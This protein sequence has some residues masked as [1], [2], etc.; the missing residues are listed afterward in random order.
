MMAEES[1]TGQ[2]PLSATATGRGDDA[3]ARTA[4]PDD[5]AVGAEPTSEGE[6]A[7]AVEEEPEAPPEEEPVEEPEEEL[8]INFPLA[9]SFL[10]GGA[11]FLVVFLASYMSGNH[12]LLAMLWGVVGFVGIASLGYFIEFLLN[13]PAISG[14]K[15]AEVT[16][17][18]PVEEP[19]DETG[20]AGE[21]IVVEG[22]APPGGQPELGSA[23][24]VTVADVEQ[25]PASQ[26]ESETSQQQ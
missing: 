17:G 21:G 26:P 15:E 6:A 11:A 22:E 13:V 8:V 24:D 2:A 14:L 7:G 4:E 1:K 12:V 16:A 18:E 9:M 19:V 10:L 5:E 25:A 23:I 3:L 20:E